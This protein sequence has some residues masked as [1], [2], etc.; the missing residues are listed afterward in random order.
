[1]IRPITHLFFDLGNVLVGL[2]SGEKLKSLARR[3]GESVKTFCEKIWSHER[4]HDYERGQH[5]WDEYFAL[6]A[7]DLDLTHTRQ[8]LQE[9]FCDIFFPLPERVAVARQLAQHYPLSLISNTCAS[10]IQHLEATCDFFPLFQHRIYSHEV[11]CR[12]PHPDIYQK[13]LQ[14]AG[15][16]PETSLFIDDL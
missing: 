12:K 9:A 13:A 5:T 14:E 1:M 7:E 4:A 3:K 16:I 11:G 15:A 2:R 6:L 8:E 10:H